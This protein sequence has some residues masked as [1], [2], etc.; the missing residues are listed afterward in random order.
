MTLALT[1]LIFPPADRIAMAEVVLCG[2]PA[3]VDDFDFG[4]ARVEQR[5]R[6]LDSQTRTRLATHA[7]QRDIVRTRAREIAELEDTLALTLQ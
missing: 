7:R 3:I 1:P 6:I 2:L 4:L 5:Q